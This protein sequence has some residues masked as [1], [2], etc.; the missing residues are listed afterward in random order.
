MAVAGKTGIGDRDAGHDGPAY[1][2]EIARCHI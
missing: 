1:E 2:D